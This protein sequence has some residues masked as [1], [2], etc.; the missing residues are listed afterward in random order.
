MRLRAGQ[1]KSV[2]V[3]VKSKSKSVKVKVKSKSESSAF[4]MSTAVLVRMSMS[5]SS[6]I[7][8][9]CKI[10]PVSQHSS[11]GQV[12]LPR[13]KR[14]RRRTTNCKR[15][16]AADAIAC[17]VVKSIVTMEN[18]VSVCIYINL[19]VYGLSRLEVT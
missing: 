17:L 12:S 2:K 8:S 11:S 6:I 18:T 15:Q 1:S 3:K 19:E 16:V 10:S 9:I 4:R 5:M 7:I 13:P 14:G